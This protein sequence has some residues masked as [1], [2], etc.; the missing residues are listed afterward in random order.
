MSDLLKSGLPQEASEVKV[1]TISSNSGYFPIRTKDRTDIFDWDSVLGHVVKTSYRKSLSIDGLEDF[2]IKCEKSF[3]EKL[4]EHEL[5]PVLEQM[6]FEGDEL[7]KIAPEFLLFKTQQQSG[8]TPNARLGNMFASLLDTFFFE[9]KPATKL[10]FLEQQLFDELN[11]NLSS[12]ADKKAKKGVNEAPYL[13]FMA[14]HFQEDLRFL[15]RRPKYLL[16]V[17]KE[18][19]KLYSHLY[20][21]QLALNIRDWRSGEPQPKPNYFILD[22]EKASDERS[23]I[24]AHGHS[25]L[26]KALGN[27]FPYIAM[28]DSLQSSDKKTQ[29]LWA[30]AQDIAG[31]VGSAEILNRYAAAFKENRKLDIT[32]TQ[33]SDPLDAL[34]DLL[35]LATGQFARGES[36]H[37]INTQY[38]RSIESE[39]CSHF[40]QRRGRA[41]QVLV[42][43]QDYLILLTN[44]A[45]GEKEKLRFHELIKAF[46]SRG[47]FFDKQTQQ[48]LIEFYERIGNVERMSDSGDAVYVS[49]TI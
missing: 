4:D 49:K 28:N 45:I 42:F 13:P 7:Y 16:S 23:L 46:E 26:F 6:Y 22:S 38:V 43:N 14:T 30:L 33:N 37:E 39:L 17:F 25:Q 32:L 9:D 19:L 20:T 48:V 34:S 31:N 27:V 40:V 21:A 11:N 44:L 18:F 12:K 35:K 29:P 47:V 41:G 3:L 36:R 2:K 8:S 24:K 15:G 1:N 5:W 10:N